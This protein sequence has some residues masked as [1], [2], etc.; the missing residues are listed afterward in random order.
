MSALIPALIECIATGNCGLLSRGRGGG[1]GGGGGS[2]KGPKPPP[3][4][5]A[6]WDKAAEKSFLTQFD[7]QMSFGGGGGRNPL[8]EARE[9]YDRI[10]GQINQLGL[11]D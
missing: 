11:G 3:D 5:T 6:A 7:N 9:R 8:S 2:P 4:P 10:L 1:G